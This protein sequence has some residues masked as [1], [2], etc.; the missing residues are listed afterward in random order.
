[1]EPKA[2]FFFS[3]LIT[4]LN[5]KSEVL[6]HGLST[7]L[8]RHRHT[9]WY[10]GWVTDTLHVGY[11]TYTDTLSMLESLLRVAGRRVRGRS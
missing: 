3:E 7:K 5:L 11:T 6:A 9:V 1:M 8:W 2:H 4:A 10:L